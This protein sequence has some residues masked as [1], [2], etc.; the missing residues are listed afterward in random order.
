MYGLLEAHLD[1][2]T[3]G[4]DELAAD[5]ATSRP[6]L[7]RK[8]TSVASLATSELIQHYRPRRATE[9]LMQGYSSTETAYR[10][11]FNTPAYFGTVSK[12]CTV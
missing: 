6:T 10:V 1:E 12:I 4:V 9:L 2:P 11:G 5:L 8:C 3:Y 7:Y